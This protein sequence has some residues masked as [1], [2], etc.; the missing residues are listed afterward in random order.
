MSVTVEKLPNEQILIVTV[1]GHL[2]ADMVK[3]LY[4]EISTLTED[5]QP[6]IYRVTD[7]RKMSITFM[8]LMGVIKEGTK[9]MPGTTADTRISHMFVG[10][11]KFAK[12]ARDVLQKINPDN[13]PML[14]TMEEALTYIRWKSQQDTQDVVAP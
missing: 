1:D 3:D 10:K 11:D 13:H 8:D 14:D 6:P 4:Q 7:V 2:D 9:D 5:M 12:I